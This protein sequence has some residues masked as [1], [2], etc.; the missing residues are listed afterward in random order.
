MALLA[1]FTVDSLTIRADP[2][3]IHCLSKVRANDQV[4]AAIGDNIRPGK[5]RSYRLDSGKFEA[6]SSSSAKWR[7]PRIQMIFDVQGNTPPYRS[8]LVTCEA[9][10]VTGAFPP[11]LHTSI[12]KIDYETA[13]NVVEAE[14]SSNS[15]VEE[16]EGEG[17]QSLWLIG[18]RTKYERVSQRSGLSL[19]DLGANVSINKGSLRG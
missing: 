2:V 17:D 18:D 14:S 19:R 16:V 11:K 4:I 1:A 12:L 9:H 5:L 8:A 10:K 7:D 6:T 13:D 3:Y 15:P